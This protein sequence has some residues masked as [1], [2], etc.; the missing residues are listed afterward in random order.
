[1]EK[2]QHRTFHRFQYLAFLQCKNI[3][4][5]LIDHNEAKEVK[6]KLTNKQ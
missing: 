5:T 4:Q 2:I 1:M 3:K 6:N